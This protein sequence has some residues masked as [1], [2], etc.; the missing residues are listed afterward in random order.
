VR[1]GGVFVGGEVRLE[2]QADGAYFQPHHVEGLADQGAGAVAAHA[3]AALFEHGAGEDA[4]EVSVVKGLLGELF[5][6]GGDGRAD[7]A[8]GLEQRGEQPL[9][10]LLEVLAGLERLLENV[11]EQAAQRA[12][13]LEL[14]QREVGGF[15][16][17]CYAVVAEGR[18]SPR[19]FSA[20]TMV[21]QRHGPHPR[22]FGLAVVVSRG[23][24][25]HVQRALAV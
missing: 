1:A 9:K 8:G 4:A 18:I 17:H 10:G 21:L 24:A 5:V 20:A 3:P 2:E 22:R 6:E 23:E 14:F 15:L 7:G 19:R 25:E 12:Q 16:A 13:R 11:V